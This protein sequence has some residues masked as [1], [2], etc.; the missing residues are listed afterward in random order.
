MLKHIL[1]SR[2]KVGLISTIE[3]NTCRKIYKSTHTTPDAFIL[4]KL[5]DEMLRNKVDFC[6]MEVSSHAIAQER[7]AGLKFD[8]R[9]FTNLTPE[10]LDYHFDMESYFNVKKV[11]FVSSDKNDKVIINIDDKYGTRLLN[12]LDMEIYSYA[13]NKDAFCVA[14]N[15]VADLNGLKFDIFI[16]GKSYIIA[17]KL[18]GEFN[19][20]NILA[21]FCYAYLY[22]MCPHEIVK[23]IASFEG[24]KGRLEHLFINNAIHVFI[25][26]AHTPDAM[27]NV[28]SYVNRFSGEERSLLL[29]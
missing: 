27:Y 25:D 18:I 11:F 19:V 14:K 8:G 26:Y 24:V 7:I 13:I 22:G 4:N 12:E 23:S 29:I 9:I 21:A 2:F 5:L 17:S 28:F 6:T 10:H 1:S 15:I 20:Y 16:N 3:Y